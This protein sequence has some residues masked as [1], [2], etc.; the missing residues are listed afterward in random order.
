MNNQRAAPN[1]QSSNRTNAANMA[2]FRAIN[3]QPRM[4]G[5]GMPTNPNMSNLSPML[6]SQL[7]Q[8]QRFSQPPTNM[9]PSS[10]PLVSPT[11]AQMAGAPTDP[12]AAAGSRGVS[13]GTTT[14]N[15]MTPLSPTHHTQ[16]TASPRAPSTSHKKKT[17][18]KAKSQAPPSV[19]NTDE[20]DL[21][22]DEFDTVKPVELAIARYLR[23][24]EYMA[25]IFSAYPATAVKLPPNSW[26]DQ[27]V[28]QL[29][30]RKDDLEKDTRTMEADHEAYIKRCRDAW[31][32]VA[33]L[34]DEIEQATGSETLAELQRRLETTYADQLKPFGHI[35][36]VP[37][38]N[39]K[40]ADRMFE[41]PAFIS[42]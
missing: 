27:E 33:E 30:E 20:I 34:Q 38:S 37:E 35:E 31:T 2:A 28:N 6:L 7:S 26:A 5:P 12:A 36:R 11:A 42:L 23:N 17:A 9:V 19:V 41:Q 25:D 29:K 22:G 39:V 10:V 40:T 18:A 24:H 32:A 1:S 14:F 3:G 8:M 16:A 21:P 13:N 4:A 15:F